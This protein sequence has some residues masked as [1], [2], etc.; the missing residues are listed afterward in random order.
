M[1]TALALIAIIVILLYCLLR[2]FL[3]SNLH[4]TKVVI[5]RDFDTVWGYFAD[6]EKYAELFPN[7]ITGIEKQRDGTYEAGEVHV[8]EPVTIAVNENKQCGYLRLTIGESETS[9]IRI[10]PLEQN[11][12]LAMNIGYRWENFPYPFWLNFK[13]STDKDYKNAKRVIES[14]TPAP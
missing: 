5:D 9:Q 3:F 4:I 2:D 6:A 10:I 7:W 14:R 1:A 11:K 8:E 12:T 13:R